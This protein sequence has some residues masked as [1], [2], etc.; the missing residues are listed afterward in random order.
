MCQRILNNPGSL[1]LFTEKV[2]IPLDDDMGKPERSERIF[3][4]RD[5]KTRSGGK[6]W[7][8]IADQLARVKVSVLISSILDLRWMEAMT[9]LYFEKVNELTFNGNYLIC[10]LSYKW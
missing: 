6:G 5:P 3:T 9:V 10:H 2:P 8:L 1:V 4:C 7:A